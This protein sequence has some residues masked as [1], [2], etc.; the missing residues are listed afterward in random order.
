MSIELHP[1]VATGRV[2]PRVVGGEPH[3][4][5]A[6]AVVGVAEGDHVGVAGVE[7]RHRDG[8]IVR[9][10]P[11]I[12]EVGDV[13][14]RRHLRRQLLR[15]HREVRMQVDRRGMLERGHLLGDA[16][17]DRRMAVP[18]RHRDDAGEQVEV[19]VAGLVVEVLHVSL[20]DEQRLPVQGEDRR[21][22]ELLP[23]G[24]HFGTRR[25]EV[26]TRHVIHRRQRESGRA[27]RQRRRGG[28][29]TLTG[30]SAGAA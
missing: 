18:H 23:H 25:S 30:R 21:V 7:P 28:H 3:R 15:Q 14:P 16:L 27:R 10:A 12:H 20:D 9:L 26:R 8:E 19:P 22:G 24:K 11:R 5:R 4:A 2:L 13:E 1:P 6:P 17:H 29:Q